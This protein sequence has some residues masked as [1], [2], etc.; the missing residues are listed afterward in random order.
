MYDQR[1][2]PVLREVLPRAARSSG[3]HEFVATDGTG[4]RTCAFM[5]IMAGSYGGQEAYDMEILLVD[6]LLP[7]LPEDHGAFSI[8]V[9]PEWEE[10]SVVFTIKS[11]KV[12]RRKLS[13]AEDIT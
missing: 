13:I 7:L 3:F 1:L 4:L 11:R 9:M 5:G 12:L 8:S 2:V 10:L 6:E